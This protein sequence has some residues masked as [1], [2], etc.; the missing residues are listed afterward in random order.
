MFRIVLW[1]GGTSRVGWHQSL[2]LTKISRPDFHIAARHG[3]DYLEINRLQRTKSPTLDV[4]DCQIPNQNK[5]VQCKGIRKLPVRS[6][7]S[8]PAR[9]V[10]VDFFNEV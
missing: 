9:P 5:G 10:R 4:G 2:S 6:A 8:K 1:W 3:W 7:T